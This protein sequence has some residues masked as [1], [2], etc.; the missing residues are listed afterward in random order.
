M[1][2]LLTLV[3]AFVVAASTLAAAPDGVVNLQAKA[4][5]DG[6]VEISW[7]TPSG[8]DIDYYRVYYSVESILESGGAYD[9]FDETEGPET[10]YIFRDEIPVEGLFLAVM[11]V[12]TDGEESEYFMEEVQILP[13][14]SPE[15]EEPMEPVVPV[16]EQEPTPAEQE[17]PLTPEEA[18]TLAMISAKAE[19]PGSVSLSFSGPVQIRPKSA[20]TA[21]EITKAGGGVLGVQT[22]QGEGMTIL[23]ITDEQENGVVYQ[24]RLTDALRSELGVDFDETGRSAFF[25]GIGNASAASVASVSSAPSSVAA[26]SQSQSSQPTVQEPVA[27]VVNPPAAPVQQPQGIQNVT[28]LRLRVTPGTTGNAFNVIGEWDLASVSQEATFLIVGQSFDGGKTF[29]NPHMVPANATQVNVNGVPR[30]Q[31]GLLVQVADAQGRV[32][33]G[34]FETA[35]LGQQLPTPSPVVPQQPSLP[36]MGGENVPPSPPVG[37]T[38]L[39]VSM[40]P[41]GG[42]PQSGAG[43]IALTFVVAGV[44]V[45]WQ[46][47]RMAAKAA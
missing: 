42:L 23:L 8:G 28:G 46:R 32:S 36:P 9:D 10:V 37:A 35:V 33:S 38:V 18:E 31:F 29:L 39:P 2:R 47:M 4:Q 17:A 22:L 16:Q 14:E 6:T 3:F 41:T 45:G 34:V 43:F 15:G 12:N 30:G 5:P 11:A 7:D 24:V 27:P 13:V 1:Y 40:N 26:S 25:T 21:F 20:P 19:T 44:A